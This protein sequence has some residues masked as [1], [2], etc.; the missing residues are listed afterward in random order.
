MADLSCG[1]CY[2]RYVNT[3]RGIA[4]AWDKPEIMPAKGRK[5]TGSSLSYLLDGKMDSTLAKLFTF[6]ALSRVTG[7]EHV[8]SF[9]VSFA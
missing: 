4:L 5:Q 1:H 6:M 8:N 9:K 7:G 3:I 2:S